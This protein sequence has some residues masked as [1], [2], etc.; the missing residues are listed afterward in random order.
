TPFPYTTLFRSPQPEHTVNGYWMPTIVVDKGVDFDRDKMINHFQS[1]N[2]DARVFFW[3]LS[4][5]S[6]FAD[7]PENTV[8]YGLYKR[9][10]NLPSYHDISDADI[11]RVSDVIAGA[12]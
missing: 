6:M 2:I 10:L 7:K 12:L 8:S 9:A 5:L 11:A 1:H 3:P 4:M